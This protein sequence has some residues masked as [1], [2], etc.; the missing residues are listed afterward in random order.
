MGIVSRFFLLLYVLVVGTAVV[1]FAGIC[2]QLIPKQIWQTYLN[3]ILIQKETLIVLAVMFFFSLYFLG[4]AFSSKKDLK[5]V[6][7]ITLKEGEPGEVKVAV[8][9]IKSVTER[10]ALSVNGVREA[11]VVL[12]KQKGEVPIAVQLTIILGQGHAAPVVSENVV[13]AIDKAIF[14]ALQIGGVPVDVSVKDITNAVIERKQR[15]V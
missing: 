14:T 10:A 9:A 15:V 4:V 1:I 7:E 6:G 8:E 3:Y 11:K 5:A 12:L 13:N 2:L